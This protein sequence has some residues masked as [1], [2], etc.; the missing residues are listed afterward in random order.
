MGLYVFKASLVH[1]VSSRASKKHLVRPYL[2]SKTGH[3][4]K[5]SLMG[6]VSLLSVPPCY[7]HSNIRLYFKKKIFGG[8]CDV[9]FFLCWYI[10]VC[11][12][13]FLYT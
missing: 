7:N 4:V 11:M 9:I 3:F 6:R 2:L 1:T 13:V 5:F 12:T 10:C 8:D